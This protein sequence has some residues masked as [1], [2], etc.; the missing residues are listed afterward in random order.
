M[1]G[2]KFQFKAM[3]FCHSRQ[4]NPLLVYSAGKEYIQDHSKAWWWLYLTVAFC[5]IWWSRKN[6]LSKFQ[7]ICFLSFWW[8]IVPPELFCTECITYKLAGHHWA[9]TIY[10]QFKNNASKFFQILYNFVRQPFLIILLISGWTGR[11]CALSLIRCHVR[12][13][14]IVS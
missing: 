6:I 5:C 11:K 7:K 10:W 9:K 8:H 2:Q 12:W 3:I 4:V 13:I 1:H 14:E